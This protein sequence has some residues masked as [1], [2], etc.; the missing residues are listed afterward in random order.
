MFWRICSGTGLGGEAMNHQ[1]LSY[2]TVLININ[3]IVLDVYIYISICKISCMSIDQ[4]EREKERERVSVWITKIC[5]NRKNM[6]IRLNDWKP[7][8]LAGATWCHSHT[9][10]MEFGPAQPWPSDFQLQQRSAS[11][12]SAFGTAHTGILCPPVQAQTLCLPPT[13]CAAHLCSRK[14]LPDPTGGRL[15]RN[16][17]PV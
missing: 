15:A 17:G 13:C 14:P 9:P 3:E 6:C 1:I 4:R 7:L 2:G 8:A 5:R 11:S 10:K 16:L 12:N